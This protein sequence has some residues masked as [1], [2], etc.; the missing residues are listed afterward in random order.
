MAQ[1]LAGCC[2]ARKGNY[3]EAVDAAVD[4]VK[5][6]SAEPRLDYDAACVYALVDHAAAKDA[7]LAEPEKTKIREEYALRAMELLDRAKT[8]KYFQPST[9]SKRF[10]SNNDFDSIKD[11]KEVKQFVGGLGK[12]K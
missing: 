4:V 7:K 2:L 12:G 5:S 9:N 8:K 1:A 3:C 11:R 6:D 10:L